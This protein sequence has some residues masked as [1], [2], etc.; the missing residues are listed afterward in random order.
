[1]GDTMVDD[2]ME[3][4]KATLDRTWDFTPD[5]IDAITWAVQEIERLRQII[6]DVADDLFDDGKDASDAG[7]FAVAATLKSRSARLSRMLG[8]QAGEE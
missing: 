3:R 7:Y 8:K 4:L 1:M 5:Q 2:H 6:A